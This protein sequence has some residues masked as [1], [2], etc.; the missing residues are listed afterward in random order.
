M[1]SLEVHETIKD[2]EHALNPDGTLLR[3]RTV[4]IAR[5]QQCAHQDE[6]NWNPTGTHHEP[7]GGASTFVARTYA[8]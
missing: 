7:P 8:N 4:R 1:I 2:L 6:P 5:R 3:E